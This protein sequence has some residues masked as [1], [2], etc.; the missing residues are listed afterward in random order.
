MATATFDLR[1]LPADEAMRRFCA[2]LGEAIGAQTINAITIDTNMTTAQ[3]SVDGGQAKQ[4]AGGP[5]AEAVIHHLAEM[6][7]FIE[8]KRIYTTTPQPQ[9]PQQQFQ[10]SYVS[11]D[12]ILA[13]LEISAQDDNFF[14]T[15]IAEYGKVFRK[16]FD[17]T[18]KA[19][20]LDELQSDAEKAKLVYYERALSDLTSATNRLQQFGI[21]EMEKQQQYF[22]EQRNAEMQKLYD[23]R[24]A[25]LEK[26]K[27]ELDLR[28]ST[29]VR[30]ALLTDMRKLIGED[31]DVKPKTVSR[32]NVIHAVCILAMVGGSVLVYVGAHRLFQSE[33]FDWRFMA[34]IWSGLLLVGTTLI[35]YLRWNNHWFGQLVSEEFDRRKLDVDVLRASWV[36]EM[37]MEWKEERQGQFPAELLTAFT[38]GLFKSGGSAAPDHHP[39]ADLAKLASDVSNLKVTNNGVE[40]SKK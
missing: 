25:D 15:R 14:R 12:G 10:F 11:G 16:H 22:R 29:A 20:I 39:S 2:A 31:F 34:T 40:I 8:V 26:E 32:R 24:F 21:A 37:L 30:R 33:R 1:A 36:A 18:R 4:V 27:A 38:K 7:T 17:F 23:T 5:N 28:R 6:S 3:F 9:N 35:Y 13:R 19:E